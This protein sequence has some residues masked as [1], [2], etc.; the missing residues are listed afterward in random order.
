MAGEKGAIYC[1]DILKLL[2]NATPIANIADNAASSPLTSLYVAL[3]T[4]DPTASGDQTSNEIAY[5]SYARISVARSN[6]S[7]AWTIT[8]ASAAPNSNLSF[9]TA[10]GGSATATYFSI[11][12]DSSGTGKLL[13]VGTVSPSIVISTGITPILASNATTITEAWRMSMASHTAKDYPRQRQQQ[14][15]SAL[16]PMGLRS[17]TRLATGCSCAGSAPTVGLARRWPVR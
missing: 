12:T 2:L 10:T 4:A 17:I 11:G 1:G 8:G 14:A 6:S 7:P 3:H 9:P 16:T 5:T 13:Y 15:P